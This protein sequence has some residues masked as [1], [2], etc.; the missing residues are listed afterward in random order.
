MTPFRI[1]VLPGDGIGPEVI[2]AS[3]DVLR[4]TEARLAGVRFE[5]TFH[6]VDAVEY[7]NN[8]Y[9]IPATTV[10]AFRQADAI[11]LGAMGLTVAARA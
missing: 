1:A 2:T 6:S 9:P 5:L 4:A 3:L 10:A 7:L 8:G 11:L